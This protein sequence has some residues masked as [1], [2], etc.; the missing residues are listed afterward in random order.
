MA[1]VTSRETQ[2]TVPPLHLISDLEVRKLLHELD[3]YLNHPI[4]ALPQTPSTN[5]ATNTAQ[6]VEDTTVM[7]GSDFMSDF[8][9]LTPEHTTQHGNSSIAITTTPSAA[10]NASVLEISKT[11]EDRGEAYDREYTSWFKKDAFDRVERC[12]VPT[13]ANII[14]SHTVYRRKDDG[15]MK[16]R[17][18][19]W[20]HLHVER[21]Y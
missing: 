18:L 7:C 9:V 11:N 14:G 3:A 1:S 5:T 12:S 10:R 21:N 19:P 8:E 15:S 17:I 6:I 13:D 4:N 16:A 20:G 2:H